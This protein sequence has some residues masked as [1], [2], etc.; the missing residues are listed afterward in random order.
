MISQDQFLLLFPLACEW[1]EEQQ[2][3]ILRD[4][5]ALNE[6]QVAYA[7]MV[8]VFE[9]EA[10]RHLA[11]ESVPLPERPDL[12]FAAMEMNLISPDTKALSLGYG[13][14]VREDYWGDSQFLIHQFVHTAQ[15]EKLGG[16]K[17]FLRHFLF[18]CNKVGHAAAPMEQEAIATALR[19]C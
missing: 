5:V 13:I 4:G 9:P 14:Y 6:E 1:A 18:E 7:R 19:L 16:L 15:C 17:A 2:K 12:R 10:I 11:V 8:G 3:I